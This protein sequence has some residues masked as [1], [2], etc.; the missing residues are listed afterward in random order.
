M[1]KLYLLP[2]YG[3]LVLGGGLLYDAEAGP[4]VAM[5]RPN[6]DRQAKKTKKREKNAQKEKKRDKNR[7]KSP[8]V[9]HSQG[10]EQPSADNSKTLSLLAD[11]KEDKE[12]AEQNWEKEGDG[13]GDDT[14]SKFE[15]VCK[16]AHKRS[17][18][19]K[20]LEETNLIKF[21]ANLPEQD[22]NADATASQKN[23]SVTARIKTKDTTGARELT[24]ELF[25]KEHDI[26]GNQNKTIIVVA[27]KEDMKNFLASHKE[28]R[29][30]L[31]ALK[32]R[33]Q[34][35]NLSNSHTSPTSPMNRGHGN[36]LRDQQ[37]F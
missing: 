18:L 32:D 10:K 31:P 13:A 25:K 11:N 33:D 1:N 12:N 28:A 36:H 27:P 37:G 4:Q 20:R 9:I 21:N 7:N 24:R 23:T 8:S 3:A 15:K 17:K 29:E 22:G 30:V 16:H 26:N 14:P 34:I 35:K 6:L 19:P 2:F 5:Q